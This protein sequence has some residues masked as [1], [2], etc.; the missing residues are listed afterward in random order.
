MADLPF[1]PLYVDDYDGAVSSAGL[2]LE[3]DGAY[4]RLLRAMWRAGGYLPHDRARLARMLGVTTKKF[5][6]IWAAIGRFFE[7]TPDGRIAQVRL[8][9]EYEKAQKSRQEKSNSGKASAKARALKRLN[10]WSTAV[11]TAEQASQAQAQAQG[12]PTSVEAE[13][14]QAAPG[15]NEWTLDGLVKAVN[16][17][18]L[19]PSK[20][21][22][23]VTSAG[24]IARWK[25]AGYDW[26]L[27]VIPV[28]VGLCRRPGTPIA[29][30]GYFDGALADAH[31]NR[32]AEHKLDFPPN[33]VTNHAR[34]PR[35]FAERE[36]D[37][38]AS[39]RAAFGEAFAR[40][41]AR[42]S[43]GDDPGAS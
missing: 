28:V 12:T 10:S 16:S 14:Q 22:G 40:A 4:C 13:R 9:V 38:H 11:D 17:P 42:R 18:R 41:A 29:K 15:S 20:S 19:D 32:T 39:Q 25:A 1:L 24:M 27:D 5:D 2:S 31:H 26:T 36:A 37:H 7:T 3:E 33:G 35:S 21:H 43:G 8:L 23:L 30:L 34:D 6:V